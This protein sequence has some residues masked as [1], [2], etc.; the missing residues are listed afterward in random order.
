MTDIIMG[1]VSEALLG[2]LSTTTLSSAPSAQVV[3]PGDVITA[4]LMNGILARLA[5]LEAKPVVNGF[6]LG[7]LG[8]DIHSLVALGT[9]FES[10]GGIFLDGNSVLSQPIG[11]GVNM[12]ILNGTTLAVKFSGVFD[13]WGDAAESTRLVTTLNNNAARYDIVAVITHDAYS[14]SLSTAAA[15]ALASVG[16]AAMKNPPRQRTNAA[17]IGV[18]PASRTNV[19]FNY[20]TSVITADNTGTGGSALLAALPLAWGIYSKPQKRFLVGGAT[21]TPA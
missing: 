3:H 21:G 12:A 7:S 1:T 16:G 8:T 2:L 4:Q 11:R 18:V 13:T 17:F 10:G 9:G 6:Q 15:D 5:A 19:S 14:L 20:L